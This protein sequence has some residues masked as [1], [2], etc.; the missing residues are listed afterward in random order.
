MCVLVLLQAGQQPATCSSCSAP[1]KM[2]MKRLLQNNGYCDPTD[3]PSRLWESAV[4]VATQSIEPQV[5]IPAYIGRAKQ[6]TMLAVLLLECLGMWNA[7]ES[8]IVKFTG[9]HSCTRPLTV[10]RS[11]LFDFSCWRT[12][13]RSID[14]MTAWP[15]MALYNAGV[16][17]NTSYGMFYTHSA[18]VAAVEHG[19]RE[20]VKVLLNASRSSVDGPTAILH[21][22]AEFEGDSRRSSIRCS[23]MGQM[24][25]RGLNLLR[26]PQ[27][28]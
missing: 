27:Y 28:I 14:T 22:L 11:I 5:G 12:E 10:V 19:F 8:A 2:V 1:S 21:C 3:H 17:H 4:H 9:G 24:S 13:W 7:G 25:M 15:S 18:L 23:M 26:T 16:D 20:I 6:I